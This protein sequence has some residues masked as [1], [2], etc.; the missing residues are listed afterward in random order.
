MS[1][2][3]A[4]SRKEYVPA[5]RKLGNL[6]GTLSLMEFSTAVKQSSRAWVIKTIDCIPHLDLHPYKTPADRNAVSYSQFP[7]GRDY[8][9]QKSK[10]R[11]SFNVAWEFYFYCNLILLLIKMGDWTKAFL[12]LGKIGRLFKSETWKI[13]TS[14]WYLVG[15]LLHI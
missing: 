4:L 6:D 12:A 15:E 1:I 9:N 13:S 2:F 8:V 14:Q 5:S 11:S 7:W 10:F 3:A